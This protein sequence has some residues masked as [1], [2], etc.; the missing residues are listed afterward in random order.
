MVTGSCDL[1]T[2]NVERV[3]GC[4]LRCLDDYTMDSRG[5]IGAVVRE[6]AMAGISALMPALADRGSSLPPEL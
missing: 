5:D 3:F 6:A 1:S 2:D 4:Y